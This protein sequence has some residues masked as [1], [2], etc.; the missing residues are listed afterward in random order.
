ME[1]AS[2]FLAGLGEFPSPIHIS[3]SQFPSSSFERVHS[4]K[5]EIGSYIAAMIHDRPS[6]GEGSNE[7]FFDPWYFTPMLLLE[8]PGAHFKL[9][10]SKREYLY[11]TYVARKR[12]QR[13]HFLRRII[14]N[15]SAYQDVRNIEGVGAGH[16]DYR[17]LTLK[18][19]SKGQIQRQG[20]ET[21]APSQT[22]EHAIQ[23]ALELFDER[24]NDSDSLAVLE[25]DRTE[26]EQLLRG[27]FDV[28]DKIYAV[29]QAEQKNTR[30]K[31]L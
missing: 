30:N 12:S 6:T 28:A 25:L 26:Y 27:A 31:C 17:R 13:P 3:G 16:Y 2:A 11:I 19:V 1:R 18:I 7:R 22:R 21:R 5:D 24:K 9:S 20:Q 4:A 10:W 15:P 29:K 8:L 23:F 14:A